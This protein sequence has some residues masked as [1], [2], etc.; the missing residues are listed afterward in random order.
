MLTPA[1]GH[2]FFG[3]S[4]FIRYGN[5]LA[6]PTSCLDYC[7]LSM[8]KTVPLFAEKKFSPIQETSAI[9]P[10]SELKPTAHSVCLLRNSIVIWDNK[11]LSPLAYLAT[12]SFFQGLISCQ[13][14]LFKPNPLTVGIAETHFCFTFLFTY[15]IHFKASAE[16]FPTNPP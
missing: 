10:H 14:L 6:S 15:S 5:S 2:T 11:T 1:L 8:Y 7:N 9:S 4:S 3:L 16:E 13:K 12:N